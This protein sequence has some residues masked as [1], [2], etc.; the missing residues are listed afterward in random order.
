[1]YVMIVKSESV[2]I[3]RK[4][5]FS[6]ALSNGTNRDE[7]GQVVQKRT[8][9]I[10]KIVREVSCDLQTSRSDENS[11]FVK[12]GENNNFPIFENL[13]FLAGS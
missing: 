1:M 10:V 8:D 2:Q 3:F 12:R 4:S 9:I 11:I 5:K 13:R 6:E 7:I